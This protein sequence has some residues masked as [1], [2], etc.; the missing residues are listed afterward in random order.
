MEELSK[1]CLE[2]HKNPVIK[3]KLPGTKLFL[4]SEENSDIIYTNEHLNHLKHVLG[5]LRVER[6]CGRAQ[7]VWMQEEKLVKVTKV[8]KNIVNSFGFQDKNGI[9]LYPEEALF[10]METNKLEIQV[11]ENSLTIQEMYDYVLNL[12]NCGLNKYLVYKKLV[13]QGY[14]V[15]N[16]EV[17]ERKLKR[18]LT[19]EDCANKR[20]LDVEE[21]VDKKLK[22]E[23]ETSHPYSRS[24]E[25]KVTNVINEIFT[26]LQKNGPKIYEDFNENEDVDYFVFLPKNV[27]LKYDFRVFVR[28]KLDFHVEFGTS[29]KDIFG[30]CSNGSVTFYK[31]S[32][33]SIP[34]LS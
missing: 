28:S 8:A 1:K 21:K 27:T 10:L 7:S 5:H 3:I 19:A 4:K 24:K 17:Y 16:K 26:K 9:Y 18:K 13:L 22:I 29:E 12:P 23:G 30:V 20:K 33:V 25:E 14:K 6:R 34:N 15:M 11:N 2:H 31:I 32:K